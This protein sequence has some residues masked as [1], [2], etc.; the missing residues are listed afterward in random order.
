VKSDAVVG[1]SSE[2]DELRARDRDE[3][4]AASLT[5]PVALSTI[6]WRGSSCA[7]CSAVG[8]LSQ[9]WETARESDF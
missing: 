3:P 6:A 8:T 5:S 2:T 9:S 4:A 7:E 1:A